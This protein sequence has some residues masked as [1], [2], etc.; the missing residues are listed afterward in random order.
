MWGEKSIH[1]SIQTWASVRKKTHKLLAIVLL[2]FSKLFS[3]PFHI[4]TFINSLLLSSLFF[5]INV[6]F[7]FSLSVFLYVSLPLYTNPLIFFFFFYFS[8]SHYFS[9]S[10]FISFPFSVSLSVSPAHFNP[11]SY[12]IS[13]IPFANWILYTNSDLSPQVWHKVNSISKMR[14]F[15]LLSVPF[16]CSSSTI[17]VYHPSQFHLS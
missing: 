7:S 16:L 9:F 14:F 4:R 12:F 2:D 11:L 5:A 13:Q 8:V 15:L 17:D 10:L 3:K 6:S 1:D